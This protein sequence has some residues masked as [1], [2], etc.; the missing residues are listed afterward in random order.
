MKSNQEAS[1]QCSTVTRG[2]RRVHCGTQLTLITLLAL[3]IPF[4]LLPFRPASDPSAARTFIRNYFNPS[5]DPVTGKVRRLEGEHLSQELRL[6]EPMVR[7]Q[8]SA[9][10]RAKLI[11]LGPLQCPEV[12]LEQTRRWGC[13]LGRVRAF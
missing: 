6:T 7:G 12:V 2:S 1:S 3:D 10:L 9:Q 11:V 5:F 8:I 13:H 4:L